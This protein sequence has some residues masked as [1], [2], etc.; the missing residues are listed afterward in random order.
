MEAGMVSL[1]MWLKKP[2]GFSVMPMADRDLRI[3]QKA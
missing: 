1:L 3:A 2:T